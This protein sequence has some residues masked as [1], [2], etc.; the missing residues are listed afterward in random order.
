MSL[1]RFY[2][3]PFGGFDE[4]NRLFDAAFDFRTGQRGSQN[5]E[6]AKPRLDLYEGPDNN[7]TATFDLP[8][9]KKEDVNIE[10]HNNRL[11]VTGETKVET[12]RKEDNYV[13]RERRAGKFS[14]S[15]PLP[16]G[17]SA[18]KVKAS[19]VDGVLTITFPKT[20]PEQAPKKIAIA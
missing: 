13:V 15:L 11:T 3:E 20:S 19:F 10:V 14:R 1:T 4:F 9:L 16:T 6:S 17:V 2:Y 18:E 5:A 8:G 7:I 12:D